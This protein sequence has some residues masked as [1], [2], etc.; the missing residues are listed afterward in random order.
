MDSHLGESETR[1]LPQ[2]IDTH[3]KRFKI[4]YHKV[5]S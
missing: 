1:P 3:S 5:E 2:M 4:N